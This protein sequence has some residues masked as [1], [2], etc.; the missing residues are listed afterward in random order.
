MAPKVAFFD[1]KPYDREYFDAA[2]ADGRIAV[3]YFPMKLGADTAALAA[4]YDAVCAFVNDELDR[5]TLDVLEQGGVKLAAMRCAGYNN[6]DLEAAF[7][8]IHVVRVPAYSPHAVAEHAVA[9]LLSLNRK[10]HKAY[11]RT[12]DGNFTLS[13]LVGFDLH[14]KT[15]GIVGTGQIGRIAAGILAGFGMRI[16]L[17]DP[18]PDEAWAASLGARYVD[19]AELFASADVVSLHCPLTAD[20]RYLVNAESLRLMK[21]GAIVINTGRGAL[22]DTKALVAA[23]KSGKLGGAGL[24]VYEEE[25][26]YFFEDFSGAVIADDVLARLLTFPNVLVTSHQAFLT[27]EALAAIAETTIG[28]IVGYFE[29]GEAP[30]EICYRC[31]RKTCGRER[32]GKCF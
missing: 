16:L 32:T 12:R 17:S 23:L 13:G 8:R 15:A 4:G 7:G 14:G 26:K 31:G 2:N 24:D 5:R 22:I 20:T 19:R 1:T 28:N 30:N 27:R 25:D 18:F 3:K 21:K 29:R 9:L 11:H 10:T 6:V